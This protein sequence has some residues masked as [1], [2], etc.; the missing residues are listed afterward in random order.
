MRIIDTSKYHLIVNGINMWNI[1]GYT[2][3]THDTSNCLNGMIMLQDVNEKA[4]KHDYE[5]IA[6]FKIIFQ[7]QNIWIILPWSV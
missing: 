5:E 7:K 2:I 1:Q 6:R 3:Y 4:P